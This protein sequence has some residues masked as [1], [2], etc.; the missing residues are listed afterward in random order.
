MTD[1]YVGGFHVKN[2]YKT[3]ED[4]ITHARRGDTIILDKSVTLGGI[5]VPVDVTIDGNYK[6]ITISE[7]VA[8][9]ILSQNFSLKKMNFTHKKV[10]KFNPNFHT[11]LNATKILASNSKNELL[12]AKLKF[13][14]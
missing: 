11:N 9:F 3:L 13:R 1:L 6:T 8:G 7:G 12:D 2:R 5:K 14:T 10:C 4:A